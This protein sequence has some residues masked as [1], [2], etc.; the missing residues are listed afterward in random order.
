ME[1]SLSNLPTAGVCDQRVGLYLSN[2]PTAGVCDQHVGLYLNN[3]PT[4]GVC[5]Q[6]V[7]VTSALCSP[8]VYWTRIYKLLPV[9]FTE[10]WSQLVS[11]L[12]RKLEIF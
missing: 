3:L 11:L 6:H 8:Q 4:T 12:L 9:Q 7:G 10:L 2:L 1:S 5:D